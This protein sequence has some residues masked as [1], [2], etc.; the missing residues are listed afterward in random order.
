M[1]QD[2]P[3]PVLG[4]IELPAM[5]GATDALWHLLMRLAQSIDV[6]WTL[7][8]GQMVML[9]GLQRGRPSPRV[10][11]DIDTVIDV[12]TEPRGMRRVVATLLALDLEPA[13][14]PSPDGL[15]HRYVK[16][17]TGVAVDLAVP[18][19]SVDVLVPEGLG[20]TADVGTSLGGRAFPVQGASQALGRTQIVPVR[21]DGI[22]ANVP[23]PDLLGA[24]VCKAVAAVVDYKSP[25]RHTRDLAFLCTLAEDPFLLAAQLT[26][27]DRKRMS[28]AAHK[29]HADSATWRELESFG[30]DGRATWQLL[31][32]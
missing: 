18:G 19:A 3:R 12:R 13:G 26:S 15:M 16:P 14:M 10:S 32:A 8:G 25:E 17:G 9:H 6:P 7:V 20:P 4:T 30:E 5:G 23:R 21:Y 1:S 11:A 2:I 29:L 27:K 24:I 28:A 22:D 31:T